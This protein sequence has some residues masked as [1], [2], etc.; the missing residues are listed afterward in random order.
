MLGIVYNVIFKPQKMAAMEKRPLDIYEP[1][2]SQ[3]ELCRAANITMPTANNW[4]LTG[5]LHP[6]DVGSRRSRKPRLF[7]AVNC[8]E[9]KLTAELVTLLGGAPNTAANIARKTT[10][11]VTWP[12]SVAKNDSRKFVA[13]VFWSERCRDW[14]AWID[15]PSGNLM[16]IDGDTIAK[17]RGER[18][19]VE[20]PIF[21]LP[22]STY[23]SSV[24]RACR[25]M[26]EAEQVHEPRNVQK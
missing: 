24:L 16:R 2:F 20:R 12:S 4:I 17:A 22:V 23:F 19:L 25:M 18:N 9:A 7:S 1:Q 5:V 13:I 6:A 10:H 21:L 8:F 15:I 14:D 11:D 3:A 26:I